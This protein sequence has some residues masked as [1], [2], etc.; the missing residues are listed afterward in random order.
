MD[1]RPTQ[2]DGGDGGDT[3]IGTIDRKILKAAALECANQIQAEVRNVNPAP[4]LWQHAPPSKASNSKPDGQFLVRIVALMRSSA[5]RLR[6]TSTGSPHI[7]AND[8][9]GIAARHA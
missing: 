7:T 3:A 6:N 5:H 1:P 8:L 4:S 2:G 9:R